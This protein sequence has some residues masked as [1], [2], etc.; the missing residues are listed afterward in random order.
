MLISVLNLKKRMYDLFT[1][2][3]TTNPRHRVVNP[4][5]KFIILYN[6]A[7]TLYKSHIFSLQQAINLNSVNITVRE[8]N[9]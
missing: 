7:L 2:E 5:R 9:F 8:L 1:L 3:S 6:K 4:R